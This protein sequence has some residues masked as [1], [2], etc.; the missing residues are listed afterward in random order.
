MSEGSILSS[1]VN[2]YEEP[3]LMAEPIGLEL[4]LGAGRPGS[5]VVNLEHHGQGWQQGFKFR[6][7]VF[8]T[9]TIYTA[10]RLESGFQNFDTEIFTWQRR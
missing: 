3:V 9:T 2:H 1:N 6:C 5:L 10:V 8:L 4:S 7:G